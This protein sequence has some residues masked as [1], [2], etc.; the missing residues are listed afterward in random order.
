M[1]RSILYGML[2][3]LAAPLIGSGVW[4]DA[5]ARDG[6]PFSD[7]S[8]RGPY[9][10]SFQGF[11]L[12]P[13]GPVPA[14]A[15]G[16]LRADGAGT[17][18]RLDRTLSVGGAVGTQRFL[19]GQYRVNPDGTGFACFC[20]DAPQPLPGI[21]ALPFGPT[22]ETFSFVITDRRGAEA[23][24]LGTSLRFITGT[25]PLDLGISCPPGAG[26]QGILD[27]NLAPAALSLGLVQ[28]TA[29]SQS[30]R[31]GHGGDDD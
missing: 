17:F 26:D 13:A 6:A 7:R 30:G 10:F 18:P 12:D 2:W 24:F 22:F 9:G 21:P 3:A 1:R 15:V 16:R 4:Q 14:A 27:A 5:Q 8:L 25:C 29:Q 28:G 11:V 20:G 31:P 19:D 23:E